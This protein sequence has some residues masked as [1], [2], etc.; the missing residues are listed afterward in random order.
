M[1]QN[2]NWNII[3]MKNDKASRRHDQIKKKPFQ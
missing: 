3:R 2:T 1:F